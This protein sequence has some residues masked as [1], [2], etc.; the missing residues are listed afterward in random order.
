MTVRLRRG[1]RQ[2]EHRSCSDTLPQTSQKRTFSRTSASRCANRDTSNDGDWRMWK[3]MRCADL[4][5]MPG[6]RPNSSISS[7]TI[8]SYMS[9]ESRRRLVRLFAHERRAEHLADDGLAVAL[10]SVAAG[11]RGAW[12]RRRHDRGHREVEIGIRV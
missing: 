1:S 6:R 3:V 12:E 8:P 9:A 11:L 10:H 5:P 4:G 7:W 2:I